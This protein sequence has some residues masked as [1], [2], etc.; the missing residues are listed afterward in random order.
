MAAASGFKPA[1]TANGSII[2]PTKATEGDGQRKREKSSM[3][4]PRI[5]H[6]TEGVFMIFDMGTIIR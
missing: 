1:L 2:A 4:I 3:V 5:H 6:V